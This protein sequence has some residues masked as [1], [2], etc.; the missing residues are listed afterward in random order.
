MQL[1]RRLASFN[2]VFSFFRL[3]F[4]WARSLGGVRWASR[5]SEINT[6]LATS[7]FKSDCHEALFV[8][9]TERLTSPGE[10][11]SA[12]RLAVNISINHI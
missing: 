10:L 4:L 9:W 12:P 3:D 7:N 8:H 6:L 5:S 1:Q 2:C 11:R